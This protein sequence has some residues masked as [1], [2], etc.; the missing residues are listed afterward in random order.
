MSTINKEWHLKNKMPKNPT[1]K[2]RL[3]WHI[4]HEKNC[5]CRPMP[6]KLKNQIKQKP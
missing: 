3:K 1:T 6:E 4:E 2:Q 5:S